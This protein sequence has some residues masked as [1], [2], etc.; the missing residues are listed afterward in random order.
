MTTAAADLAAVGRAV[1]HVRDSQAAAFAR[2]SESRRARPVPTDEA[3]VL[4]ATVLAAAWDER[5]PAIWG[6][7]T[8]ADHGSFAECSAIGQSWQST[9]TPMLTL[10]LTADPEHAEVYAAELAELAAAAARV[11][12]IDLRRVNAAAF[13]A[14]A[15]LRALAPEHG[16]LPPS[17]VIP[18]TRGLAAPADAATTN[19]TEFH[20]A[21][22]SPLA[23]PAAD[24]PPLVSAVESYAELLEQLDELVGLDLVKADVRRQA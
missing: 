23:A 19:A 5:A 8:G 10:L 11:E 4:F 1:E 7:V 22:P 24:V 18:I 12:P 3:G 13:V 17:S 21:A 16:Q 20:N 6:E 2:L 14:A 15:Q 9:P